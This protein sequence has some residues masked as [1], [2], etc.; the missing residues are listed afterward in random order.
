MFLVSHDTSYD[1]RN[2]DFAEKGTVRLVEYY[3]PIKISITQV[4]CIDF[5]M[6]VR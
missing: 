2:T 4:F 6:T 5:V 1:Y 3:K